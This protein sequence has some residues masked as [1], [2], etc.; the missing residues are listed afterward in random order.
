MTDTT[1]CYIAELE[2]KVRL[3]ENGADCELEDART[4][5]HELRARAEKAEMLLM[6]WMSRAQSMPAMMQLCA[7]LA[8][9]TEQLL[10]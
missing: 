6:R 4:D 3:Y 2:E 7:E 1:Y 5:A 10:A 9:E 8:E